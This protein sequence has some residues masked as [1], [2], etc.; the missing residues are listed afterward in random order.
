MMTVNG[1]SWVK[2]HFV[3]SFVRKEA[4][5]IQISVALHKPAWLQLIHLL[6]TVDLHDYF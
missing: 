3:V 2:W 5:N 4:I 1:Y 6:V